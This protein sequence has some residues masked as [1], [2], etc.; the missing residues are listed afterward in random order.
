MIR[1]LLVVTLVLMLAACGFHLRN[2]LVLPPDLGPVRVQ[3]KDRYSPLA[4]S[5][6]QALTRAGAEPATADTPDPAVLDIRAEKWDQTPVS[7]DE[8]GRAQ[9]FSLRYAVVFELRRGDGEMI[10]PRQAIELSR[11]YI[12][13]PTSSIGTEDEREILEKE[14]RRE[15]TASILRRID[16][17]ARKRG[18]VVEADQP[19]L[20]IQRTDAA[21]AAMEAAAEMSQPPAEDAPASEP[22]PEPASDDPEEPADTDPPEPPR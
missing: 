16:A 21:R 22:D 17:V 18:A 2:A 20:E 7:V 13:V 19:E 12:S 10:V 1:R 11:D 4:E 3:A 8:R 9:E 15:M 6:A 14:L 5:L